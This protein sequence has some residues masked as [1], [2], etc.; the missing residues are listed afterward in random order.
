MTPLRCMPAVV[1]ITSRASNPLPS[2]RRLTVNR[3][4]SLAAGMLLPPRLSISKPSDRIEAAGE[5]LVP[6]ATLSTMRSS[7]PGT[8]GSPNAAKV[9]RARAFV[10]V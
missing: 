5:R 8:G 1:S 3:P 2:A 7:A 10:A 9:A 6:S 4:S